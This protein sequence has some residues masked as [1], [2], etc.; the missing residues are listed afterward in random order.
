MPFPILADL[1]ARENR[2]TQYGDRR[3]FAGADRLTEKLTSEAASTA[4]D[5]YDAIQT[6][7][8]HIADIE[9]EGR[10]WEAKVAAAEAAI[11]AA[12]QRDATDAGDGSI[13]TQATADCDAIKSALD[14]D[15]WRRRLL[16]AGESLRAAEGRLRAHLN[17]NS[18]DL[19]REL[20]AEASRVRNDLRAAE[21]KARKLTDPPR[22]EYGEIVSTL[23]T[24]LG[25]GDFDAEDVF[26]THRQAANYHDS[27]TFE[28]AEQVE[29]DA[30]T[31]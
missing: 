28:T 5:L 25:H 9:A 23:A 26:T 7:T 20:D 1:E 2:Q 16:A 10:A 14:P 13:V 27:D 17:A 18:P 31:A 12:V 11:S 24:I 30:V 8:A 22:A 21:D 29:A 6:Q 19:I 15:L 4:R 3:L